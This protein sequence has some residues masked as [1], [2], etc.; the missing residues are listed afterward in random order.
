MEEDLGWIVE[1]QAL[2]FEEI[3]LAFRNELKCENGPWRQELKEAA[4]REKLLTETLE[5]RQDT[6]E[7]LSRWFYRNE[8]KQWPSNNN[9]KAEHDKQTSQRQCSYHCIDNCQHQT[10]IGEMSAMITAECEDN[11][12]ILEQQ[13]LNRHFR[14]DKDASSAASNSA[15]GITF[16]PQV[17]DEPPPG[18]E[19]HRA[20]NPQNFNMASRFSDHQSA[21]SSIQR[22]RQVQFAHPTEMATNPPARQSRGGRK[23]A[24]KLI[25]LCRKRSN[26]AAV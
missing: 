24:R 3:S 19:E 6:E 22:H 12:W 17:P 23:E 25:G 2:L 1:Q 20:Q 4:I 7:G 14:I 26:R 9:V 10:V 16:V 5:G 15:T 11:E 21:T 13:N 8:D 18:Y